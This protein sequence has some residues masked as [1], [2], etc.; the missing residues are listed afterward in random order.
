VTNETRVAQFFILIAGFAY[1]HTY[2]YI[3]AM[4][5]LQRL[6]FSFVHG[7]NHAASKELKN[8]RVPPNLISCT[9][10]ECNAFCVL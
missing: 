6:Y 3:R 10:C 8:L 1:P 4:H 9:V 7:W 2:R 5:L